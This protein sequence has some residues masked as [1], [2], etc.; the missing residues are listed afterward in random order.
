MP[1]SHI[2]QISTIMEL[3][4]GT[5]PRS[6]LDIGIGFGKYG[7]LCREYLELWDGRNQYNDWQHRIDG[8]EAF[9]KYVT[10]LQETIYDNIYI[11]NALDVVPSL[12]YMYDLVLVIDVI[13]HFSLED[14]Q[15]L[16]QQ[17]SR[18][19]R[20]CLISTPVDASPQEDAFGNSFERHL[21]Q[22]TREHFDP[23]S[24]KAF[25]PNDKSLLC[26][27]RF[28]GARLTVNPQPATQEAE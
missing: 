28:D 24:N 26:Y 13:E 10:P 6:V 19:G 17:C 20:G 3:V 7:F 5:R 22:W 18:I 16:L 23:F 12:D 15:K 8:I 11:G 21:S 25:I 1:S 2:S 14:G 27:I 9:E 4:L